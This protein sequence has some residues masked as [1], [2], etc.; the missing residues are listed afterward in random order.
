MPSCPFLFTL[1]I[2]LQWC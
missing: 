1:I 2:F